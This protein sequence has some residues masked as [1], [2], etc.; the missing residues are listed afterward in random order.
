MAAGLEDLFTPPVI[1][2]LRALEHDTGFTC[3]P[4]P[5]YP[6][7][8]KIGIGWYTAVKSRVIYYNPHHLQDRGPRYA[9]PIFA[10]ELG[11]HHPD[12]VDFQD[13]VER[14][15]QSFFHMFKDI[16]P[17]PKIISVLNNISADIY[18][19]EVNARGVWRPM[20]SNLYKEALA[21]D[22]LGDE[23]FSRFVANGCKNENF[24]WDKAVKPAEKRSSL[25][26]FCNGLLLAA[27]FDMPPEGVLPDR[28]YSA[29]KKAFGY[30]QTLKNTRKAEVPVMMK[31]H[32][33]VQIYRLAAEL[34]EED[35]K[36][37]RKRSQSG[38]GELTDILKG[39]E[40]ELDELLTEMVPFQ[41]VE[42]D[43]MEPAAGDVKVGGTVEDLAKDLKG[44]MIGAGQLSGDL[45]AA[46]MDVPREQL[47]NY[48]RI[49]LKNEVFVKR[50]TDMLIEFILKDFQLK[51]TR[52]LTEGITEPGL[53]VVDYLSALFGD[54]DAPFK[55]GQRLE[56]HPL[57]LETAVV[58]DTSGSMD[59]Y[60][61]KM[62]DFLATFMEG[63]RR[64]QELILRN[65]KKYNWN[66]RRKMPARMELSI[67]GDSPKLIL[68][69]TDILTQPLVVRKFTEMQKQGGGTNTA[70]A[71]EFEYKRLLANKDDQVVR[72]LTLV[73][74]GADCGPAFDAIVKKIMSDPRIYFLVTGIGDQSVTRYIEASY[75][76]HLKPQHRYRVFAKGFRNTNDAI[77]GVLGFLCQTLTEQRQIR[78]RMYGR[79]A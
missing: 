56:L 60:M 30:V 53:E 72:L 63:I 25:S 17:G 67:F 21:R 45:R 36:D 41:T 79:V 5:E 68:G 76:T 59:I 74:D 51:N 32:A 31:V 24:P 40:G 75:R 66:F 15:G 7:P 62:L 10:H 22:F 14:V 9:V 50:L 2:L 44:L 38:E 1:T 4:Y 58:L 71:L 52:G 33:Q 11:H 37:M 23:D 65:P 64:I 39:F 29:L 28:S 49:V 13:G 27:K 34:A 20:M 16:L 54:E 47:E 18:L 19:E 8:P 73:T 3:K 55:M 6:E 26:H 77:Q 78:D 35:Y 61:K 42:G 57:T 46:A 43:G 12:V 70:A 69:M 48:E